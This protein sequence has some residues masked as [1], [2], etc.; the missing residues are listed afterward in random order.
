MFSPR[1]NHG[2]T[3]YKNSFIE[4]FQIGFFYKIYTRYIN[5]SNINTEYV[6]NIHQLSL[7]VNKKQVYTDFRYIYI[8]FALLVN[9]D[10]IL[11]LLNIKLKIILYLSMFPFVQVT[12]S[13][14]NHCCRNYCGVFTY[15][16]EV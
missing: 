5:H 7:T 4:M 14:W 1:A 12:R 6:N 9:T 11:C 16:C 10:K 8:F 2:V 13:Y 3:I 15:S